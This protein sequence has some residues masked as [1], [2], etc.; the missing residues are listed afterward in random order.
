MS[1]IRVL[2]NTPLF[3][4]ALLT[5]G[6]TNAFRAL[7]LSERTA[8]KAFEIMG[9]VRPQLT[10]SSVRSKEAPC[11]WV[12][13]ADISIQAEQIK[14]ILG[15]FPDHKI[16]AEEEHDDSLRAA[17]SDRDIWYLDGVDGTAAF[18]R[19]TENVFGPMD[20]LLPDFVQFGMQ[21]A[22]LRDGNPMCAVFAAPEM[23]IDG[24]GYSIFEAVDGIDGT[25]L[26][27]NRV[28]FAA[29]GSL[30]NSLSFLSFRD[31]PYEEELREH[32]VKSGVTGRHM[33]RSVSTGS[34][35][36]LL[37]HRP[38]ALRNLNLI[39]TEREKPWDL[40]PGAF[41]IE[42]AGGAIR[43]L[44]G[45]NVF[46]FSLDY[47]GADGR[48]QPVVAALLSNLSFIL[49]LIREFNITRSA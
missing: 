30:G 36:A 38:A 24:S 12:T 6:N 42:K 5:Q 17:S 15:D 25:F 35:F 19:K 28:K 45:N 46:P 2:G 23:D 44:D 33:T 37:I 41:L 32:I 16:I 10:D 11:D 20:Y 22:Y 18:A 14:N 40:I 27:G 21:M 47:L 8:L 7:S 43:F 34:E 48:S 1:S 9:R 49:S 26:N 39:A 4:N 3:R 31:E 29:V 13:E